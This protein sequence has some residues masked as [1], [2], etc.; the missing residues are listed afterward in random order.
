MRMSL[1][2]PVASLIALMAVNPVM[3]LDLTALWDFNQPELSESRFKQALQ[4]A[5][6]DDVLILHTQIARSH[7]L[8]KDFDTARQVLRDIQPAIAT[9]GPEAQTRFHMEM[10]R[11]FA[12]ATHTPAQ[13]TSDAR[14]QARQAY[15]AALALARAAR[16]D[17]LAVDAIHMFAFL[18]TA[19]A[20]QL[21]WGQVALDVVQ[22]S[23]QPEARRREAS[24]R[25]N[26]GYA[27]H[28]LGRFEE[29]LV[30]FQQALVLREA[31]SNANATH[32]A[33]WM[34]GW[35]LRS[36]KRY[37]EALAIQLR[38][39]QTAAAA[40]TP[41][42]HVFEELEILF[43]EAGDMAKADHYAKRKRAVS[44]P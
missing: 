36:L 4:T 14:A 18:D 34:V 40:S 37:N 43:T 5:N 3:A 26:T 8:R 27:L 11:T 25:H 29:A 21:K 31:G 10:G 13:M 17:G 44:S 7:G 35:T 9:A 19:P 6:G 16:L 38:L 41:D 12:S 20:D 33:R 22:S 2:W 32:V 1:V 23:S 42:R 15:D 30:Q 39:E 24:V 28:Q